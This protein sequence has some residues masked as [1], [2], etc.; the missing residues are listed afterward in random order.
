MRSVKQI[1]VEVPPGLKKSSDTLGMMVTSAG[2]NFLKTA[3]IDKNIEVL[4]VWSITVDPK[5][6]AC[7]VVLR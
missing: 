6:K 2:L 3:K 5:F 1:Y 4:S 7:L